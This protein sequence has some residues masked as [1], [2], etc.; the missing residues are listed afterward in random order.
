[1]K[2][3]VR[4]FRESTA[5][6]RRVL[7]FLLIAFV[8]NICRGA[9]VE[10]EQVWSAEGLR[11]SS[12]AFSPDDSLVAS[13]GRIWST[14][15]RR[16]LASFPTGRR[17]T[18]F[19]PAGDL[20]AVDDEPANENRTVVRLWKL[21]DRSVVQTLSISNRTIR[22][23]AF[24]PD[25]SLIATGDEDDDDPSDEPGE[26]TIWRVSD[27]TVVRHWVA[28]I[29]G[30]VFSVTYSPDG[31]FLVSTSR[32]GSAKIWDVATGD[33]LRTLLAAR[34]DD[35]H[36]SAWSSDGKWIVTAD[37]NDEIKQWNA[38]DGS[39]VRTV[40]VDGFSEET[41]VVFSPNSKYFA[42]SGDGFSIAIWD[43]QTGNTYRVFPGHT[44]RVLGVAF[45]HSGRRLVSTSY[46]GTM[47]FWDV[48]SGTETG[49]IAG[50][51]SQV[52]AITISHDGQILAS[53]EGENGL[54]FL[55]RLWSLQ[56]GRYLKAIMTT[57]SVSGLSFSPTAAVLAF[58][59][60]YSGVIQSLSGPDWSTSQVIGIH[61]GGVGAVKF[62][63]DGTLIASGCH[64]DSRSGR[65][66]AEIRRFSDGKLLQALGSSDGSGGALAF[67]SDGRLFAVANRSLKIWRIS[68]G[69]LVRTYTPDQ[70]AS[71]YFGAVEFLAGDQTVAALGGKT[72]IVY[73]L[74]RD[75]PVR[76]LTF[77]TSIYDWPDLRT[78]SPD[79]A[80][81]FSGGY[82][83]RIWDPLNGSS[84]TLT[85]FGSDY[86][87][88]A[89]FSPDGA[90]IAIG[91]SSGWIG[92]IRTPVWISSIY[93]NADPYVMRWQGP[94]G[95]YQPQRSR[96]LTNA[97]W[98]NIGEATTNKTAT[99]PGTDSV[100]FFRVKRENEPVGQ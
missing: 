21:S 49:L 2:R 8:A 59:S 69:T 55:I 29:E 96:T 15:T 76:T 17:V 65:A 37:E 71:L 89:S 64:H 35:V 18:L 88:A 6:L 83:P 93:R 70:S 33:L 58:G 90:L 7:S 11:L 84:L 38:N 45:S 19:S 67:S 20:I 31:R 26:I 44:W 60:E 53:V 95:S 5:Q 79:S 34:W 56:E 23:G 91:R 63:P 4:I 36:S 74:T 61:E 77:F 50:H 22:C 73:D 87:S 51:T 47:R 42:S 25:G 80:S 1:M 62:S 97:I 81:L 85:G 72:V 27:G 40:K 54:H 12:V 16:L 78:A 28:H 57:S 94:N 13:G 52:Q 99:I 32:D 75:D 43:A 92:V 3:K 68:D 24:S 98:E 41:P 86:V 14:T 100:Q 82:L 9:E 39:L 30:G 46:E 10:P 66:T 48:D